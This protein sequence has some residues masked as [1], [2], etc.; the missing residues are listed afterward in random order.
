M[1]NDDLDRHS[2][3]PQRRA[4]A[5]SLGQE[6]HLHGQGVAAN[7]VVVGPARGDGEPHTLVQLARGE[8]A[9]IDVQSAELRP[10]LLANSHS[11]GEQRPANAPPTH[12]RGHNQLRDSK[13][14]RRALQAVVVYFCADG[15]LHMSR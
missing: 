3:A 7:T 10:A 12:V 11:V 6:V 9:L 2:A 15:Q 13:R 5:G 14:E 4:A 1:V 8:V